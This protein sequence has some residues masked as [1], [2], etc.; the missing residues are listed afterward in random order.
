MK[1]AAMPSVAHL[2]GL[3]SVLLWA[4]ITVGLA[5]CMLILWVTVRHR[6]RLLAGTVELDAP[7]DLRGGPPVGGGRGQPVA[8]QVSAGAA[9]DR[10]ASPAAGVAARSSTSLL[11]EIVWVLVPVVMMLGLGAWVLAG[12]WSAPEASAPVPSVAGRPAWPAAISR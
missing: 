3:Q 2:N 4:C 11:A 9:G 10:L 6:M 5:G 7:L 1:T 8:G 12:L